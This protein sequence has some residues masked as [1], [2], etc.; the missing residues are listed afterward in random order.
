MSGRSSLNLRLSLT[1]SHVGVSRWNLISDFHNKTERQTLER[2][3]RVV[4]IIARAFVAP[5]TQER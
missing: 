5:R 4:K 3:P 1:E 2:M